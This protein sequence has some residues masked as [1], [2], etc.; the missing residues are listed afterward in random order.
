MFNSVGIGRAT[1][2]SDRPKWALSNKLRDL[3]RSP[4][5]LSQSIRPGEARAGMT[6]KINLQMML[7]DMRCKTA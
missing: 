4:F 7:G 2:R 5:D 3:Q 1:T 6:L